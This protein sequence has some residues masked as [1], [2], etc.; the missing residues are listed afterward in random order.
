MSKNAYLYPDSDLGID[1]PSFLLEPAGVDVGRQVA[2]GINI[3]VESVSRRHANIRKSGAFWLLS[4]L[5]SSNGTYVNGE[6]ITQLALSDGDIITLGKA[7]LTFRLQEGYGQSADATD[8][9]SGLRLVAEDEDSSVILSTH[10]SDKNH[11]RD[12]GPGRTTEQHLDLINQRLMALY[13]LSDVL[14]DESQ[15]EGIIASL[16]ALIFDNL[17]ADRGVA[18][19][20]DEVTEAL[21]PEL[22]RL[23]DGMED[24]EFVLSKSITRH[25]VEDRVAVLSRDVRMDN[26]FSA[27]ESIMLSDIRSAMCV[28]LAGKRS[29][30]GVVFLDTKEAVHSFTEDDLAFV[31]ALATD[32][33]MTLE[34]LQLVEENIQQERLAAVGQTI[35]ELAH[36][37]KNILQLARGGLELMDGAIQQSRIDDISALWPITKR[38]IERM[39]T[40]TME[41]LDFSRQHKP[42][43]ADTDVNEIL[44]QL[45]EI[46]NQDERALRVAVEL[47][48]DHSCGLVKV[49]PDGLGKALMNLLSNALDALQ[50]RPDAHVLLATEN[51]KDTLFIRVKDNGPGI[52]ADVLPRI[53]QPFY[54]TKGSKGNGLGLSMTRKY[55]EDMGCRLD[56][57]TDEGQGCE[58][59][60]MVRCG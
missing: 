2:G 46:V 17:P 11:F 31:S 30:L 34:N 9:S 42:E 4:D 8:N 40:L 55:V 47:N 38:S 16:M 52:P 26:R 36:N 51:H 5:Q 49:D 18:L 21:T 39:Q 57:K 1:E 19:R 53:F 25:V 29:L 54:S 37:I 3:P 23:R 14:R 45:V 13:K 22:F 12:G 59:I 15:R 35:S 10:I 41:M 56:V 7:T 33:A 32:A 60:I 43:L 58:F 48:C 27:S 50:G 20:Y 28:P 6:R 44:A 24:R